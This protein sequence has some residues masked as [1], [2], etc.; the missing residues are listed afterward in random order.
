MNAILQRVLW[1][2]LIILNLTH[3]QREVPINGQHHATGGVTAA[4]FSQDTRYAIVASTQHAIGFWDIVQ[5][6]LLYQW[7]NDKNK[8]APIVATDIDHDNHHAITV[9][10]HSIAVWNAKTGHS[11]AF[12]QSKPSIRDA[13]L[14]PYGHFILLGLSDGT[15]HYIETLSGHLTRLFRQSKAIN[16]VSISD[17]G[18]FALTGSDDGT[19][20]LWNIQTGRVVRE[21][22]HKKP[23]IKVLF[24]PQRRFVL[25]AARQDHVY[26]WDFASG[27]LRKKINTS[28]ITLT[29]AAFSH[30]NRWLVFGQLPQQLQLWDLS[31]LRRQKVWTLPK[32]KFWQPTA[33]VVYALAFD[34]QNQTVYSEDSTGYGYQWSVL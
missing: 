19:A 7:H 14:E 22:Q 6:A 32:G 11:L 26:L 2:V 8:K 10:A 15:A 1:T 30:D 27:Q 24:S 33:T 4:S 3:C 34:A 25:T 5:H 20:K 16:S 23:V 12:W 9:D 17:D 29:A 21:W 31:N 28:P 13:A 18:R